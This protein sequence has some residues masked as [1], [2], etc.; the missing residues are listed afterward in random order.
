MDADLVDAHLEGANLGGADLGGANLG[1]ANLGVPQGE[2]IRV[3]KVVALGAR[4]GPAAEA[5]ALTRK[6]LAG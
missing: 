1:G 4:R 5:R 6:S 3:V 2:R